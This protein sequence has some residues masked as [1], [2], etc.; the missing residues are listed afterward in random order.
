MRVCKECM[1][2]HGT[3]AARLRAAQGCWSASGSAVALFGPILPSWCKWFARQ[4]QQCLTHTSV[5]ICTQFYNLSFVLHVPQNAS[6]PD[7]WRQ[8]LERYAAKPAWPTAFNA[9]LVAAL[10]VLVL[11]WG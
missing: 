3:A 1:L 11:W 9:Y 7:V 2:L 10:L 6:A 5:R 8:L 4:L